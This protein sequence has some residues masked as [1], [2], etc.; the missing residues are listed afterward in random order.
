MDKRLFEE[1]LILHNAVCA[2]SRISDEIKVYQKGLA[3]AMNFVASDIEAYNRKDVHFRDYAVGEVIS[4]SLDVSSW[5]NNLWKIECALTGEDIERHKPSTTL[6]GAAPETL[7]E[8][9]TLL[10]A[11][12]VEYY[13]CRVYLLSALGDYEEL[14]TEQVA[15]LVRGGH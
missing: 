2:V 15:I 13:Q 10:W 6:R 12:G 8:A 7:G 11:S 14:S 9:L 1:T 4:S 3:D 5:L